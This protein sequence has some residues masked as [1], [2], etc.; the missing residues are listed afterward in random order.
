[1]DWFAKTNTFHKERTSWKK[2]EKKKLN[3][4]YFPPSFA[5][6]N[7]SHIPLPII[8]TSEF[9]ISK[10]ILSHLYI[11]TE[12]PTP[13]HWT[14]EE[15][16]I[17]L[18]CLLLKWPPTLRI[19]T[20]SKKMDNIQKSSCCNCQWFIISLRLTSAIVTVMYSIFSI[21]KLSNLYEF[22]WAAESTSVM[23]RLQKFKRPE[24]ITLWS[25]FK[26]Q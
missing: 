5:S 20:K 19:I 24:S 7:N 6:E 18:F 13:L 17:A 23:L 2:K 14:F 15:Y 26:L 3:Q 22:C 4:A 12:K 25:L 21:Y 1:M 11:F 8:N 9:P 10:Y 16:K